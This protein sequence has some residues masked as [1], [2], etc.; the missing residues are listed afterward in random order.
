MKEP[1]TFIQTEF[2]V[3]S[4]TIMN[5]CGYML[6]MLDLHKYKFIK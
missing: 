2:Y 1:N 4:D 6:A 3:F 5:K